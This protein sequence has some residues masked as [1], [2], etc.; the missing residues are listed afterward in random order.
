MRSGGILIHITIN[1]NSYALRALEGVFFIA[2]VE[3]TDQFNSSC[4]VSDSN[5]GLCDL[6]VTHISYL[7]SHETCAFPTFH[8]F[9]LSSRAHVLCA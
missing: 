4:A 1:I 7:I 2:L 5:L 6:G 3:A 8:N 9:Q